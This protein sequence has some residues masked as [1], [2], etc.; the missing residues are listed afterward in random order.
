[1]TTIF[2]LSEYQDIIKFKPPIIQIDNRNE[3][4]G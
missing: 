1:M 3:E 2:I 4:V